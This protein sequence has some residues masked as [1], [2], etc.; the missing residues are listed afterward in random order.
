MILFDVH[1][2]I[3]TSSVNS[4]PSLQEQTRINS[5]HPTNPEICLPPNV[6]ARCCPSAAKTR[7]HVVTHGIIALT[8]AII[9][10]TLMEFS[11]ISS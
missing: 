8:L 3:P 7:K 9:K 4:S 11:P 10:Y 2:Y 6:A 5:Q 1:G